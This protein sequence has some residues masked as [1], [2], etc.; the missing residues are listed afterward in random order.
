L[1]IV[2]KHD[3]TSHSYYSIIIIITMH[4]G[5]WWE[6]QKERDHWEIQDVG[7]LKWILER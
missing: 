6:S 3:D 2:I 5:Y 7:G 4:T 1:I